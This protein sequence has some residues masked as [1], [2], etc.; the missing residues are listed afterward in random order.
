MTTAQPS[1][2]ERDEMLVDTVLGIGRLSVDFPNV[3]GRGR[4][5]RA[6]VEHLAA[7]WPGVRAERPADLPDVVIVGLPLG[8]GVT[9]LRI[10]GDPAEVAAF[11]AALPRILAEMERQATL[12]VRAYNRWLRS[13]AAGLEMMPSEH[14]S[15]ARAFRAGAFDELAAVAGLPVAPGDPRFTSDTSWSGQARAYARDLLPG[16][17]DLAAFRDEDTTAAILGAATYLPDP[18]T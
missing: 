16:I 13:G 14:G 12:A 11:V 9:S 5:R 3:A 6:A 8:Q 10:V 2:I 4:H 1:L 15:V 7:T 18:L 17:G